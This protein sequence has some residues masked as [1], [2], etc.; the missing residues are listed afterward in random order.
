MFLKTKNLFFSFI[1]FPFFLFP[2]TP[3]QSLN[4]G[5][6]LITIPTARHAEEGLIG[7]SYSAFEPYNHYRF[8]SN[9]YDW[10][11]VSFFYT[12]INTIRYNLG[13][14]GQSYKDKGF[15][16]KFLLKKEDNLPS[17]SLYK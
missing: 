9:P 13:E 3:S 6:G 16:A 15:S 12:D 14:T 8:Y 4:H 7:F 10:L 2:L 11:E 5:V 17:I 1:L